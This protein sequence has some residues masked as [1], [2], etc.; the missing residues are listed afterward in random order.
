MLKFQAQAPIYFFFDKFLSS[1]QEIY[2]VVYYS[3]NTSANSVQLADVG[4]VWDSGKITL[5]AV[6]KYAGKNILF[7]S[8]R[9]I[10]F[11]I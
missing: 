2:M 6:K 5:R 11:R 8:L 7:V 10:A 1:Y 3:D 4:F 9:N